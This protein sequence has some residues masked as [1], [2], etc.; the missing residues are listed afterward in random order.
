MRYD[1]DLHGYWLNSGTK[2][3]SCGGLDQSACALFIEE[4]QQ[5]YTGDVS[6]NGTGLVIPITKTVIPLW[7]WFVGA[8]AAVAAISEMRR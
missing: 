3:R 7:M 4:E 1:K 8:L 5:L 6:G 2:F